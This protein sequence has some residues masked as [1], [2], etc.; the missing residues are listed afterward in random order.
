[1]AREDT[2]VPTIEQT[3]RVGAGPIARANPQDFGTAQGTAALAQGVNQFGADAAQV[4]IQNQERSAM[5]W[6]AQAVGQ[7]HSDMLGALETAKNN[8][9]PGA[10]GFTDDFAKQFDDYAGQMIK[11]AP[12]VA[13]KQ[14]AMDRMGSLR[15]RMV[16]SAQYYQENEQNQYQASQYLDGI[17][18]STNA[19]VMDPSQLPTLM[20]TMKATY[21]GAPMPQAI[22]RG[23]DKQVEQMPYAVMDAMTES[24][25]Q[26]A[27]AALGQS[28]GLQGAPGQM[29]DNGGANAPRGLRNNNPGNLRA[30]D[31]QWQ[32]KVGNDGSYEQFAT[33][34]AGVRAG[35]V[36]LQSMVRETD[37]TL[38]GVIGKWAPSN[39]NDTPAYIRDV[40]Q[41]TGIASTTV[42]DP[43]NKQQMSAVLGAMFQHENNGKSVSDQA[44]NTGVNAAYGQG[45]LPKAGAS[46]D[47]QAV[48]TPTGNFAVDNIPVAQRVALFNKAN[49][50]LEKGN[51]Q[52]RQQVELQSRDDTA[53]ALTG[54]GVQN[55]LGVAAFTRAYGDVEGMARYKDYADTLHVGQMTTNWQSSTP[56]Q[57]AQQLEALKPQTGPGY[58]SDLGL[59]NKAQAAAV[60][61]VSAMQKDPQAYA[62]QHQLGP[63]V[64][65]DL[66]QA[67]QPAQVTQTLGDGLKQQ[68]NTAR[69]MTQTRQVP[70]KPLS[71]PQAAYLG[72][73]MNQADPNAVVGAL[74]GIST[75]SSDPMETNAVLAQLRQNTPVIAKA[76]TL[77]A[78][79][80]QTD[81]PALLVQG[82]QLLKQKGAAQ[83]YVGKPEAFSQAFSQALPGAYAGSP[84]VAAQDQQATMAMYAQLSSM[85]GRTADGGVIDPKIMKDAITRVIG[86]TTNFNGQT[87]IVPPN[88][89]ADQFNMSLHQHWD[90][91]MSKNG[92]NPEDVGIGDVTLR[93]IS[94][95]EYAVMHGNGPLKNANGQPAFINFQSGAAAPGLAHH[96]SLMPPPNSPTTQEAAPTTGTGTPSVQDLQAGDY[97]G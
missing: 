40:S 47:G 48:D 29:Q 45:Q 90:Q 84:A 87:T 11:N 8:A 78:N 23:L 50:Q 75:A 60:N 17:K 62:Q 10:P 83:E 28:L 58:A 88:M 24:N 6:S 30:T 33:P 26:A 27:H 59:Y 39:E 32:G 3:V 42:L 56:D 34:E 16:D 31:I 80:D 44:F 51:A 7:A 25:P 20:A 57:I 21:A 64:S 72:A 1:M 82:N 9:A 41:K 2:S 69:M 70:F 22:K 89:D 46:Q 55:P 68:I 37:G 91:L 53:Q 49:A 4:N 5:A 94:P 52:Y 43:S 14:F 15:A 86:P 92:I 74:K 77:L 35:M 71:D 67:T 81:T 85:A 19:A 18:D 61:I 38:A 96:V 36:N 63:Q 12:T 73:W 54:A 76:G 95:T 66:S 65:L 93:R 79:G 97:N 13:A